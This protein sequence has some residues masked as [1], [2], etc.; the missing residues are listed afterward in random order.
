MSSRLSLTKEQYYN[1]E[2]S[3]QCSAGF[4][5]ES[6]VA[7][8]SV[9]GEKDCGVSPDELKRLVNNGVL[10]YILILCKSALYGLIVTAVI[11]RKKASASSY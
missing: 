1:T 3:F 10:S 4:R 6:K 8:D 9:S 5:G 7:T 11:W 2:N